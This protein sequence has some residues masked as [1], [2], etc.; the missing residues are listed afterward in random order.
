[1]VNFILD[2]KSLIKKN[3]NIQ[4]TAVNQMFSQKPSFR[5]EFDS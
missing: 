2:F 4:Y 5:F 3:P 1:M